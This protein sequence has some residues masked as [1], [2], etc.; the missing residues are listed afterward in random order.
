MKRCSH[1]HTKE[2]SAHS[3]PSQ[4]L[5][6]SMWFMVVFSTLHWAYI[7]T[8]L[9]FMPGLILWM[10][11]SYSYMDIALYFAHRLDCTW[12]ATTKKLLHIYPSAAFWLEVFTVFNIFMFFCCLNAC[13]Y[14][15]LTSPAFYSRK[16]DM[17]SDWVNCFRKLGMSCLEKS[18]NQ[19]KT[20]LKF[21]GFH[22]W[23]EY[24]MPNIISKDNLYKLKI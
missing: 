8:S 15:H 18:A 14:K 22:K 16:F 21:G 13:I 20:L 19:T 5:P 7:N 4:S 10:T 17:V 1:M 6:A 9:R 12:L 2:I 3:Q 24:S 11:D 23:W